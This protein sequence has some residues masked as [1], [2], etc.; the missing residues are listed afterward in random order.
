[1]LGCILDVPEFQVKLEGSTRKM[2]PYEELADESAVPKNT[3]LK[4]N[5]FLRI[6]F[7]LGNSLQGRRQPWKLWFRLERSECGLVC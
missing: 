6:R 1:M 7:A 3:R 2:K 4:Y 5:Q